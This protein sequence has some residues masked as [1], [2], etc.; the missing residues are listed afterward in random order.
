[1]HHLVPALR[2]ACPHGGPHQQH[3]RRAADQGNGC[4]E[5]PLVAPTVGACQAV[6]IEREA[7]ALNTPVCH[8]GKRKKSHLGK[9]NKQTLQTSSNSKLRASRSHTSMT[10]ARPKQC[11]LLTHVLWYTLRQPGIS[12]ALCALDSSVPWSAH[13]PLRNEL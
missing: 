2:P 3:Q 8:L 13:W 6:R 9:T 1:M 12:F 4:G 5:F 10:D 7:Q 11:H